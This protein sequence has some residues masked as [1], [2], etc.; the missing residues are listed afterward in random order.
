VNALINAGGKP[1]TN[2]LNPYL[3]GVGTAA[4]PQQQR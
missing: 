2:P 1:V 3:A 4:F